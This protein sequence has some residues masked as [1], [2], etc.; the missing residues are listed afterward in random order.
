MDD[1][2]DQAQDASEAGARGDYKVA[3][4]QAEATHRIATEKCDALQGDAQADCKDRA[5]NELEAAK[6][7][8]EQRRDGSG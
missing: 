1:V 8:A 4:A 7:A 5:D 2:A 3:V 6:R